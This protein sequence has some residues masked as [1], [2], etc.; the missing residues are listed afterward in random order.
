MI[1]AT[2]SRC[3]PGAF[4]QRHWERIRS[5]PSHYF[6]HPYTIQEITNSRKK[7]SGV[8]RFHE[9]KLSCAKVH[10]FDAIVQLVAISSF[11][12][13]RGRET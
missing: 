13:L 12:D 10:I 9:V 4:G 8:G 6:F 1:Q 7:G 2:L 3:G 11:E 5:V